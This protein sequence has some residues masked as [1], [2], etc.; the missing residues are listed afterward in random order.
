[1]TIK[2]FMQ[3]VQKKAGIDTIPR[4]EKLV[5]I[6]FRLLSARLTENEEKDL[7]AQ[8]S[9]DLREFWWECREK[10][11]DIIKFSKPEFLQKVSSEGN[12]S[13]E[14]EA[15]KVVKAVFNAIKAQVS[16]GEARDVE[17]QLPEGLKRM[18]REA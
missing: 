18:W 7:T 12:L 5:K 3:R 14:E 4:T 15:E 2:R 11:V 6:V 10:E 16:E 17:A 1:M 13:G 9:S 8:F